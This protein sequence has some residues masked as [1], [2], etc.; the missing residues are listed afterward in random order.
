MFFDWFICKSI[1][2][3]TAKLKALQCIRY[4]FFDI[5]MNTFDLQQQ[6]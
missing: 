1:F 5:K 4:A 3:A 6:L 2:I